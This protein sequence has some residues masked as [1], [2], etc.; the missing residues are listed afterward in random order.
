MEMTEQYASEDTF[1]S[2]NESLI[3]SLLLFYLEDLL[4]SFGDAEQALELLHQN[5]DI[6]QYSLDLFKKAMND[7]SVESESKIIF[8]KSPFADFTPGWEDQERV[9]FL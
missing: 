7:Q 1:Y 4:Q 6:F 8:N 2:R 9:I 5:P 3:L